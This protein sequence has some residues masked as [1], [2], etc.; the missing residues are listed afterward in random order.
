MRVE[1]TYFQ[2]NQDLQKSGTMITP[3]DQK[4]MQSMAPAPINDRLEFSTG[5]QNHMEM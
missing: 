3:N 2:K 1:S 5:S 4:F